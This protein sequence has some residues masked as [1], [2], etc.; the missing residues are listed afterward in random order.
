MIYL[1]TRALLHPVTLKHWQVHHLMCPVTLRCDDPPALP[2]SFRLLARAQFRQHMDSTRESEFPLQLEDLEKEAIENGCRCVQHKPTRVS[3]QMV[4]C[5]RC[6]SQIR[7][8]H[9]GHPVFPLPQQQQQHRS[10]KIIDQNKSVGNMLRK[11]FFLVLARGIG[12]IPLSFSANLSIG[13][14]SSVAFRW[15]KTFFFSFLK[16]RGGECTLSNCKCWPL[17][18]IKTSFVC[19]RQNCRWTAKIKNKKKRN[20]AIK[21]FSDAAH[22][23]VSSHSPECC[24]SIKRCLVWVKSDGNASATFHKKNHQQKSQ[25]PEKGRHIFFF[26]R[27]NF[28]C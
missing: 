14:K 16:R 24:L 13:G 1:A 12:G 4:I 9:P 11:C 3:I 7:K 22:R 2:P 15:W 19:R 18:G 23:F 5:L 28:K 17:S 26:K 21:F 6:W 8:F 25:L 20:F 27:Y 10:I